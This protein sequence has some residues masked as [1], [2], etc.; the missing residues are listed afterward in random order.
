MMETPEILDKTCD[1]ILNSWFLTAI[2]AGNYDESTVKAAKESF[3]K[4]VK[5]ELG[6][7]K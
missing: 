1:M 7:V 6:K 5:I 4:K 3:I 2:G